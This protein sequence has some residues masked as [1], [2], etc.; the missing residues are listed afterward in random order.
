MRLGEDL[1]VPGTHV[2][3][4]IGVSPPFAWV[5]DRVGVPGVRRNYMT[6][7]Y[8]PVVPTGGRPTNGPGQRRPATRSRLSRRRRQA[9]I[10]PNANPAPGPATLIYMT[11]HSFDG[12]SDGPARWS[13]RET[14]NPT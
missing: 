3:N 12:G 13:P 8:G 5:A 2:L 10:Y 7:D 11:V 4:T 14:H 6:G 1:C 9:P